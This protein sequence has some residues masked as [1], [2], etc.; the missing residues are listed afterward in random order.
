M[1]RSK[2]KQVTAEVDQGPA[3]VPAAEADAADGGTAAGAQPLESTRPPRA[4]DATSPGV[5]TEAAVAGDL[6][7]HTFDVAA[8]DEASREIHEAL[9][10]EARP[11]DMVSDP[12]VR[13]LLLQLGLPPFMPHG[14]VVEAIDRNCD[15]EWK[16]ECKEISELADTLIE[17]PADLMGQGQIERLRR[18]LRWVAFHFWE[19]TAFDGTDGQHGFH[20]RVQRLIDKLKDVCELPGIAGKLNCVLDLIQVDSQS[21][22]NEWDRLIECVATRSSRGGDSVGGTQAEVPAAAVGSGLP[23]VD[24]EPPKSPPRYFR[25]QTDIARYLGTTCP[26]VSRFLAVEGVRELVEKKDKN[27]KLR[28]SRAQIDRLYGRYKKHCESRSIEAFAAELAEEA[29]SASD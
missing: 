21:H 10:R 7:D 6:Q 27:K 15:R 16:Q 29:G 3:A 17:T 5:R 22:Y 2:R 4:A 18:C 26:D 13:D 1:A 12:I 24:A 23:G 20:D 8:V 14:D 19:A 28:Y 25:Q 11:A 9:L